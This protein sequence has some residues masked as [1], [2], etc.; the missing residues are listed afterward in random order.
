MTQRD[1]YTVLG[2]SRD[3]GEDEIKKNY[4]R[5]ARKYHPDVA[6]NDADSAEQFKQLQ[7]AYDVLSDPEKRQAY[8]RFGH[9]GA[10]GA[11]GGP[12]AGWSRTWHA[13]NGS[14]GSGFNVSDFFSGAGGG[15]ADI[16]EQL[17]G[18]GGQ[19]RHQHR[20]QQPA[21][22]KDIEHTL[23]LGFMEAI[24]GTTRDVVVN[25]TNPD[26]T[27]KQERIS[28]K[29]PAGIDHG[30]KIRLR[31]KGNPGPAG[32]PGDMILTILIG[33][34]PYFRRDGLDIFLDLPLRLSEAALGTRIDV[35][36]LSGTTTV[37]IPPGSNSGKKLRLRGKGVKS[38]KSAD[39]GDMY[40]SLKIVLPD[41]LD[42]RS[43][44]LLQQ[45]E[46]FNPQPNLRNNW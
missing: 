41:E 19:A 46:Q 25:S 16:F 31:G 4:R 18:Q 9:A 13:G 40:L 22:G 36:T 12:G 26:G 30:G 1:Y 28:A 21:R 17:R 44:E 45:F 34:H 43:A 15:F 11:T 39:T 27:Q 33:E 2:V 8:D 10:Q 20:A 37:T 6:G 35:P 5:L 7:E 38:H 23:H 24:E 14:P 3:A 42:D 32:Q 29:I